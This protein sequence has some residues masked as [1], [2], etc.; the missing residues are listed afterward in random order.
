M[1]STM[2]TMTWDYNDAGVAHYGL[3]ADFVRGFAALDGGAAIATD[4]QT[5]AQYFYDTWKLIE[6][7]RAAHVDDAGAASPLDASATA[8]AAAASQDASSMAT[9]S[10]AP[11]AGT[12]ARARSSTTASKSTCPAGRAPDEWGTC[13]RPGAPH[14]AKPEGAAGFDSAH[15]NLTLPAGSYL[16][17]LAQSGANQLVGVFDL[18]VAARARRVTLSAATG[19]GPKAVGGFR[20]KRFVMR[21][22]AGKQILLLN[23]EVSDAGPVRGLKGGF[24][25]HAPG[26]HGVTGTFMLEPTSAIAHRPAA[27]RPFGNL[28]AVL[29]AL[30]KNGS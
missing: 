16:L 20:K 15:G 10:A 21:I 8:S 23:A 11:G 9:A 18:R 17:G 28:E 22:D 5:G 25:A 4:I 30:H 26:S 1:A 14:A 29:T 7:F 24:V 12:A 2:G 19:T 27:T 3:I 6:A 13:V